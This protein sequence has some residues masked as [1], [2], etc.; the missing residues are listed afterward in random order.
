MLVDT[1][2]SANIIF[3]LVLKQMRIENVKMENVQGSLVGFLGEQV[4]T[5][6]DHLPS[7]LC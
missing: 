7:N 6:G 1:G 4:L 2:N 3:L 5:V